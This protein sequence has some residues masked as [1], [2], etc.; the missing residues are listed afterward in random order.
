MRVKRWDIGGE[1]QAEPVGLPPG[2]SVT[3]PLIDKTVD[4]IPMVFEAAP[5]AAPA[6]QTFAFNAKL[7]EPP[8]DAKVGSS[9]E[10]DVDIAENGNQRSYYS[11]REDKLAVAVANARFGGPLV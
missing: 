9:V 2:I 11:I 8:K 3:A 1:I 7:T 4:T 5:D 6:A 10:H